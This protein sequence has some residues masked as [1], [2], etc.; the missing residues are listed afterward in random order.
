MIKQLPEVDQ[1]FFRD[2]KIGQTIINNTIEA[3]KYG[4]AGPAQ[5][6]NLLFNEWGFQLRSDKISNDYLA[7][8]LR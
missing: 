7:R 2:P 4:I 6:M 3:F 1:V 5:E 8:D